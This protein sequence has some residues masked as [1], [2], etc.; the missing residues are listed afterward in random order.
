[1]VPEPVAGTGLIAEGVN[2]DQSI[3]EQ[4][5]FGPTGSLPAGVKQ[6]GH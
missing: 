3:P 1:M 5:T 2:T 4:V 6:M